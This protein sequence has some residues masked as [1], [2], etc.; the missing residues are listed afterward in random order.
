[1]AT[2]KGLDLV[3]V[4]PGAN[5]PVCRFLNYGKFKYEA[6]RKETACLLYTSKSP[7]DRG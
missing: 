6:T 4:A 3:E 2:S 1:M 7:R 5:P